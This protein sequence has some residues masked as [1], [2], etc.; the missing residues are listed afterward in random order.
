MMDIPREASFMTLAPFLI[1][2]TSQVALTGTAHAVM[3]RPE[4][5]R[6]LPCVP[7]EQNMISGFILPN[8]KIDG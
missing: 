4:R 3:G 6:V 8:Q 5:R 1:F 7:A 2:D